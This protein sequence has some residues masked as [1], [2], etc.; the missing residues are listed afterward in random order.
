MWCKNNKDNLLTLSE[1]MISIIWSFKYLLNT[2]TDTKQAFFMMSNSGSSLGA[3][4]YAMSALT[5]TWKKGKFQ[6]TTNTHQYFLHHVI[7]YYC[8]CMKDRIFDIQFMCAFC[9]LF[10][11]FSL[12]QVF[13]CA[14]NVT[15][16]FHLQL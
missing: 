1:S 15:W 14:M 12:Y 10:L 2:S 4:T 3:I 8:S 9:V 6:V 16:I 7:F 11:F 13:H 5:S